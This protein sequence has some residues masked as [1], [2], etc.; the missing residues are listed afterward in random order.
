LFSIKTDNGFTKNKNTKPIKKIAT[1]IGK[2]I[3]NIEYPRFLID[4]NSLLLI[5]FLIRNEI[6]II[7]TK[8]MISFNI[9]GY[10]KKERYK[11][12]NMFLLL[13]GN[14]LD[15]SKRFKNIMNKDIIIKLI[16]KY[17]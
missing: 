1:E 15:T 12:L 4:T 8:G 11:K 17:L 6:L 10:F 3:S 9:E 2:K 7:V 13:S 5:K 14:I 16:I